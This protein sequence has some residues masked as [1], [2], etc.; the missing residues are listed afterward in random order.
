VAMRRASDY[1]NTD[2]MR[3]I[4]SLESRQTR[5]EMQVSSMSE[6]IEKLVVSVDKMGQAFTAELTAIHKRND[7]S[8]KTDWKLIFSI[9]GF[10]FTLVTAMTVALLAFINTSVQPIAKATEYN[11]SMIDMHYFDLKDRVYELQND[12]KIHSQIDGHPVGLEKTKAVTER[13]DRIQDEVDALVKNAD[14]KHTL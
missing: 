13:I 7:E 2:P 4:V 6:N 1:E 3:H 9:G 10:G 11:A 5:L 14:S 12:L 8:S